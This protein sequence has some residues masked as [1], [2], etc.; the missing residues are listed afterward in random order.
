MSSTFSSHT[1]N[2]TAIL[3]R[4]S[5][6]E[7]TNI[8]KMIVP[9][10]QRG[11][12]WKKTHVAT[13]WEDISDFHQRRLRDDKASYFLGPIVIMPEDG[14]ISLLDGQQRLATVSM[15]LCV[16][17][18][19]ARARGGQ[20]GGDLARDIQRDY[21]ILEDDNNEYTLSMNTTD[22]SFF[23]NHVQKDPPNLEEKV[24]VASHR[25]IKTTRAYLHSSVEYMIEGQMD[26]TE[27]LKNLKKTVVDYIKLVAIEVKSE[28]EA[29]FIFETLNDRGLR[30][31]VPDLL[32]NHLMQSATNESSRNDIR[33]YWDEITGLLRSKNIDVYLR[34]LWVSKYGDVKK[35][36]LFR[37]IK[38]RIKQNN[39][40][41]LKFAEEC[42]EECRVYTSITRYDDEELDDETKRDL[43]GL[44]VSLSSDRSMPLLLAGR[45]SLTINDFSKLVHAIL[46][47]VIRHAVIC[48]RNPSELENV[49]YEAARFVRQSIEKKNTSQKTLADVKARLKKIMPDDKAIRESITGTYLTNDSAMYILEEIARKEQSARRSL[50]P[51]RCTIE[52]VFPRNPRKT[53]WPNCDALTE[54]VWHI[55]NLA[56]IEEQLNRD[57]GRKS[58]E[59][60]KIVFN[61]S[62]VK[63]TRKIGEGISIW[64]KTAI[65]KQS[66]VY[67]KVIRQV[68]NIQ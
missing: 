16:I 6:P 31:S 5:F 8:H 47:L 49:L 18:D 58:F 50:A 28:E 30:L 25:L 51:T 46:A 43:R 52:H 54:H 59:E 21:I 13:F 14:K 62:A 68:F 4:S 11:F 60:K 9:P 20:G 27:I 61:K 33:S 34:H 17:R 39:I 36:G 45:Q 32:L 48:D 19:I 44:L 63:I 66:L 38:Q 65:D 22:L 55:G 12:S 40:P 64:D 2:I 37:E 15:L 1:Y 53:E 3:G 7:F 23:R 35:Q 42:R 29:Y 57:A 10:F 67:L 41:S 24:T 56:L 26:I